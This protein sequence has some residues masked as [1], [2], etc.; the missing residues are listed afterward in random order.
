MRWKAKRSR[1]KKRVFSDPVCFL[2][3]WI[4]G[5]TDTEKDA[6]RAASFG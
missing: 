6:V 4:D 3:S 1:E 2:S 5:N